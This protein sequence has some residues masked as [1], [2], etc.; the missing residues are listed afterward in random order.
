MAE[1]SFEQDRNHVRKKSGTQG[2][3]DRRVGRT[4]ASLQSALISLILDKGYDALTI[5][6]ICKVANVGR[7]T[8]YSHY[9]SKDDL[10]RGAID[11]HLRE[12]FKQRQE[13][14]LNE[15]PGQVVSPTL[16][17]F[18][19]AHDYK[20]LCRAVV[21]GRGSTLAFETIRNTLTEVLRL[22]IRQLAS[23]G[24]SDTFLRELTVQF[25]VGA[26]M[27]VLL[28][29]VEGGTKRSPKEMETF[30]RRL[31][32]HGALGLLERNAASVPSSIRSNSG[33]MPPTT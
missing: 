2:V 29:W 13:M 26:F 19:H 1:S 21:R 33:Q 6:E 9:T 25:I 5:E 3:I 28:W 24:T 17:I 22:E 16:V 4:R 32:D 27:S 30:F 18:E 12:L 14:L 31:C 8:F 20:D 11:D 7:S 23:N 10:K 15:S